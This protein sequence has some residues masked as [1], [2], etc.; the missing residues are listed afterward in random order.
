VQVKN[1]HGKF[2][3][4]VASRCGETS[5]LGSRDLVADGIKCGPAWWQEEQD[6]V[7]YGFLVEPQS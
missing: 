5:R 3:A 7:V 6:E 1:K 4:G 2:N